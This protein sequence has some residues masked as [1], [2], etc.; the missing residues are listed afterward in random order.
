[1]EF[2]LGAEGAKFPGEMPPPEPS[3]RIVVRFVP[4]TL[5]ARA[6]GA[7]TIALLLAAALTLGACAAA[8]GDLPPS[9]SAAADTAATVVA[10]PAPSPA[11][12][13][14]SIPAPAGTA[15][16][17]APAPR[18]AGAPPHSAA[19]PATRLE[20]LADTIA[21]R[22]VF[23]PL[24]QD[25][26]TATGR[27]KRLLVDFG[28][29]DID[30]KKG[31]ARLAAF[32]AA[33][34]ARSP[35]A[36]GTRLRLRGAWGSED[37]TVTGFDAWNGRIAATLDVSPTV[38]SIARSTDPLVVSAQRVAAPS[39]SGGAACDRTADPSLNERMALLAHQTEDS[40]RASPDQPIY[41]RLKASLKSRRSVAAGCFGDARGI[42]IVT[43]YAGDYEWV[44]ERILLVGDSTARR[45]TVRDLRFRAHEVLHALDADGD[46]I[47]DVAARAWTPR[48]GGTVIL[49][50]AL[51]DRLERLSA[52]F[53][54]ER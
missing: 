14:D 23:A 50:L 18:D 11:A 37:A 20:P 19:A 8:K 34:A 43:L 6:A 44:R 3:R 54:W 2:Q 48:G 47:D 36:V 40:L 51:P 39:D 10:P 53:A 9:D 33:A 29:I 31:P 45:A 25:W 28:R 13:H 46:G 52:G 7:L 12:A 21:Q 24:G 1:M 4:L 26:F 15:A 49:K 22:L 32:R 35:V 30:L 27:A 38:D 41:A 42:V 17:T 16:A 5:G